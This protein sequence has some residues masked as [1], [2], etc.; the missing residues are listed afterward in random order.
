[1]HEQ[2][3]EKFKKGTPFSE[4]EREVCGFTHADTGAW[5]ADKWK[6]PDSFCNAIRYH[7]PPALAGCEPSL[8]SVVHLADIIAVRKAFS[9]TS[10]SGYEY[11]IDNA[12]MKILGITEQKIAEVERMAEE[13]TAPVRN[14]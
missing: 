11:G 8:S 9:P 3:I 14:M 6:L 10:I 5:L 1:M 12:A 4:A 7:H 13:V 2:I